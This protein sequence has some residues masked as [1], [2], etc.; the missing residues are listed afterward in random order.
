M[1]DT[2][3]HLIKKNESRF[4]TTFGA[5]PLCLGLCYGLGD[6]IQ[7]IETAVTLYCRASIFTHSYMLCLVR[8]F[9]IMF[10][11]S[12]ILI[13]RFGNAFNVLAK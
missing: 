7:G 13:L 12:H 1:F 2:S 9:P 8:P 11:I 5:S 4:G 6:Y 10:C 3:I